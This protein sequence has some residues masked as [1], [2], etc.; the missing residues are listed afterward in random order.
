MTQPSRKRRERRKRAYQ[1]LFIELKL[2]G[3]TYRSVSQPNSYHIK[4]LRECIARVRS[5]L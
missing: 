5:K 3:V 2:L 1:L 4:F